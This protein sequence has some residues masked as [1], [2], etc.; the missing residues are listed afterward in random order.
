[1]SNSINELLQDNPRARETINK[2]AFFCQKQ[3]GN[4]A[5][6][7]E[8]STEFYWDWGGRIIVTTGPENQLVSIAFRIQKKTNDGD[9]LEF[10]SFRIKASGEVEDLP[11]GLD[12]ALGN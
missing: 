5:C 2:I 10:G 7:H 6:W 9:L 12:P 8:E 3:T 4:F 1:M 11:K